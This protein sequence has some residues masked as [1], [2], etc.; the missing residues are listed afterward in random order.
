MNSFVNNGDDENLLKSM[1][2][3]EDR[4]QEELV[5]A[6]DKSGLVQVQTTVKGKNGTYTRMQWKRA[7]DVKD[8]DKVGQQPTEDKKP[9]DDKPDSV[10]AQ[11]LSSLPYDEIVNKLKEMPVGT[12]IT[13]IRDKSGRW[14]FDTTVEKHEGYIAN[15][16][17]GNK[18]KET[19]W[20]VS[21]S[22]SHEF[23]IANMITGKNKYYGIQ[24]AGQKKPEAKKQ[25]KSDKKQEEKKPVIELPKTK[26]ELK[27]L[28][29]SG[30]SRDDI[31]ATAKANG[32]TWK[33]NDHAGIN[34]MRCCMALTGTTTKGSK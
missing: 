21:S 9:A 13:G 10:S 1:I 22:K 24:D 7:S 25:S 15:Y 26:D 34:W 28:L 23:E 4:D 16:A 5:K 11:S 29:G 14:D 30:V 32:V 33:H 20:T 18:R 31:M 3:R 8:T 27:K 19:W 17:V 6:L 12:K 2:G